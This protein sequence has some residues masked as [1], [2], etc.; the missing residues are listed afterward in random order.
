MRRGL[1]GCLRTIPLLD[2]VCCGAG[3]EMLPPPRPAPPRS[4]RYLEVLAVAKEKVLVE[5]LLVLDD[6]NIPVD[7]AMFYSLVRTGF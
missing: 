4:E 5:R 6:F 3:R 7:C 1:R 2:P